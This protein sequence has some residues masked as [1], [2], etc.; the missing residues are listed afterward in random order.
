[1]AVEIGVMIETWDLLASN[2]SATMR[3]EAPAHCGRASLGR[4]A[5]WDAF[6]A[7]APGGDLVQSTAWAAAKRALGFE[8]HQTTM[9]GGQPALSPAAW[10]RTLSPLARPIVRAL[11]AGL[12][13]SGGLGHCVERLRKG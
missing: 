4:L 2:L 7:A 12:G 9:R 10:Q 11:M 3:R 1:V 6:V 13:R 8:A 5:S